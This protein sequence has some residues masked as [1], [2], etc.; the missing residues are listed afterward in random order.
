MFILAAIMKPGQ[1]TKLQDISH[2]DS[3]V[4]LHPSSYPMIDYEDGQSMIGTGCP[5]HTANL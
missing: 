2:S 4:R 3:R 5:F 1:F